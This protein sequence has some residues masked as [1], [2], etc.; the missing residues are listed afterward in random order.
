MELE[1]TILSEIIQQKDEV[2]MYSLIIGESIPHQL[3]FKGLFILGGKTYIHHKPSGREP[4]RWSRSRDQVPKPRGPSR[5][6][7]LFLKEKYTTPQ[8]AGISAAIG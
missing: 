6:L 4:S 1:Q 5:D 7:W 3:C 2:G 8:W